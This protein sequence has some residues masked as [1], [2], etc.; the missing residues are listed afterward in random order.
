MLLEKQLL[1]QVDMPLP[2][3]F[4]HILSSPDNVKT[5]SDSSGSEVSDSPASSMW[6]PIREGVVGEDAEGVE[7][8]ELVLEELP[9]V[10]LGKGNIPSLSCVCVCGKHVCEH[11]MECDEGAMLF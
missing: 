1:P 11:N 5:L 10:D 3:T 2:S 9:V 6:R 4:S 8:V 7:G